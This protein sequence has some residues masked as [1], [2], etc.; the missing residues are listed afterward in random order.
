MKRNIS[1]ALIGVGRWGERYLE[2]LEK[3]CDVNLYLCDINNQKLESLRSKNYEILLY[4]SILKNKDIKAVIITA[5]DQMHYSL[6]RAALLH[7]KDVLVEKPMALSTREA[8]E[9]V[10][11]A[12]DKK[13]ILAVAH[14][15][16]FTLSYR[17]LSHFIGSTADSDFIRIEAFRTSRGR[18]NATSPLWDLASHDLAIVISLLGPPVGF[19]ISVNSRISCRYRLHYGNGLIFTGE[20]AWTEPPFKRTFR[21]YTKTEIKEYNEPLGSTDSAIDSPLSVMCQNFINCC[22]N[23]TVPINNGELGKE[24]VKSL[25]VLDN[26]LTIHDYEVV[27]NNS[28]I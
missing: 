11:I 23:R 1:I 19:S 6:A 22:L 14:T 27:G 25:E 17:E 13:R 16:L 9:L 3:F 28:C 4:Q 7:D 20:A 15:P 10:K 12:R 8:E 26:M 21:V 24:V 18:T 2:T 5:P